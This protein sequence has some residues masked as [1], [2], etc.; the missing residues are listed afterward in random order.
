MDFISLKDAICSETRTRN[1]PFSG[2]G[3]GGGGG[4]VLF[5]DARPAE[6]RFYLPLSN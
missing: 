4:G 5:S 6:Y 1:L 3:G 2:G